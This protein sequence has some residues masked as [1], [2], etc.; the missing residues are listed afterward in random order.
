M[1]ESL[2]ACHCTLPHYLNESITLYA[3][4][5]TLFTRGLLI[6]SQDR[7]KFKRSLR[8]KNK[9]YPFVNKN[10][11]HWTTFVLYLTGFVFQKC[12]VHP[13]S[14]DRWASTFKGSKLGGIL[15]WQWLWWV[16]I[17]LANPF[18]FEAQMTFSGCKLGPN[19]LCFSINDTT[20]HF[21]DQT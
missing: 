19:P 3:I 17:C 16:Q 21:G 10:I 18:Y 1:T 4:T 2:N 12:L 11:Q 5:T 8:T 15:H 13:N 6:L 9:L 14:N 20:Y 7:L